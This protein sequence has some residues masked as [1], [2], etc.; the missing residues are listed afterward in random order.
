M[1]D[2]GRGRRYLTHEEANE[3]VSW[4]HHEAEV[5]EE[6]AESF[7]VGAA[8]DPD[9]DYVVGCPARSLLS[10]LGEPAPARSPGSVVRDAE[11]G[12]LDRMVTPRGFLEELE[13]AV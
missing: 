6:P 13:R 4:L 7:V 5:L 10:G 8:A 12:A 11:S 2:T 3:Y 1:R 9:D